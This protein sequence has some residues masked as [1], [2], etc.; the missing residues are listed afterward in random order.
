MRLTD[1]D[2]KGLGRF[3]DAPATFECTRYHLPAPWDY[4]YTN[5]DV[6]LRVRQDGA[7]YL[8]A[9]PPQGVPLLAG[10]PLLHRANGHCTPNMFTWIITGSRRRREAFTN[11]YHPALPSPRAAA[12]PDEY[13]CTF[14]PECARYRLRR[15]DWLVETEAWVPPAGALMVMT[16]TVRNVGR[17]R[18]ACTVMPVVR[19]LL[20]QF[21]LPPWDV[22]SWYQTSAFCWV[23]R[24]PAF[25]LETRDPG[26]DPARRIRAAV[27]SDL[28]PE[29]FEVA[30]DRFVGSGQWS[31]PQAVW[32]GRLA[33]APAPQAIP[34][35]GRVGAEN[36]AVGQPPV[37]ALARRVSLRPG[38]RLRFTTVFGLLPDTAD[39]RLPRIAGLRRLARYLDPAARKRGLATLRKKSQ[40]LLARRRIDTPDKCLSR[41]VTEFLALQAHWVSVLD[42]G[43][44]SGSRGT[45]DAAQDAT[46]LVPTHPDLS[47]SRLLEILSHQ[48]TDGLFPRGYSLIRR[49][50]PLERG[51][52]VDAGAFVWELVWEYVCYTRDFDVLRE[53]VAWAD[54]DRRS[55][56]LEHVL[57]L[58]AYY[59]ARENL[60]RHGLCKI[61]GGDWN[62]SINRAGLEGRGETVMVSCQV[63]LGLEQAVRFLKHPAV[64]DRSRR[65]AAAATRFAAAAKALRRNLLRHAWNASRYFNAVFTDAGQWVFSPKDPDGRQRVNGPANS[66]AVIA[67]IVQGPDRDAVFDALDG[68]R[69]PFG[70]RLFD[71]PIG[72]P[73]IAKLGRIGQGDLAPGMGENGTPYN[74]GAQGFLGR[75]A[76]TAGRGNM[77]YDVLRYMLPYDQE[78]HPVQVAKTAPYAVVNHWKEVI[79]LEGLGG[80]AFLTG[81]IATA[82]RNVYE[83]L[84]GF[85]PDLEHVVID[86]CIPSEWNGLTAEVGFFGGRCR[87]RVRNPEHVECGVAEL[88]L[89]GRTAGRRRFDVR[90]GREVVAIPISDL[91][92]GH[93]RRIDVALGQLS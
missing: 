16:V 35:Y 34:P 3:C 14:S 81:S 17:R 69:G 64:K 5:G 39:G 59:I 83:G 61:R 45:R 67:G 87:I 49:R 7:G 32:D 6:L 9:H 15:G 11:F 46:S 40:Q 26:G 84:V 80:D 88:R 41:Y 58:F 71:P 57:R 70:W 89:N 85:R 19:P 52:H 24:R 13:A 23:D 29:L 79:G 30:C 27:V 25:W 53:S 51:G 68:L 1:I 82:V 63:V 22:P 36:A 50:D 18:R 76:W 10:P 38:G 66:F 42:R 65:V 12:E 74:H 21:G 54:S 44:P 72:H 4:V 2:L 47:R 37:A 86:P 20:A 93:N 75:A 92:A 33:L 62:D 55:S 48:G 31:G 91:R 56:V 60:G 28:K 43:W 90:L 77:L 73:P 8:Q 78:A